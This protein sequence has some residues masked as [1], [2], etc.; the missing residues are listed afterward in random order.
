MS[1]SLYV[2][3]FGPHVELEVLVDRSHRDVYWYI[4]GNILGGAY[5]E[6]HDTFDLN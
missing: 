3:Q 4:E 5:L 6:K 1:V 2:E